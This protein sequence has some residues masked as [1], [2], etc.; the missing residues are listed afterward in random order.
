MTTRPAGTAASGVGG[1]GTGALSPVTSSL[2][3]FMFGM[4]GRVVKVSKSGS[5]A[6]AIISCMFLSRKWADNIGKYNR[7]AY[8]PAQIC[9]THRMAR[10]PFTSLSLTVHTG[11]SGT[12][13]FASGWPEALAE[14]QTPDEPSSI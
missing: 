13:T 4:D 3:V 14:M 1:P 7:L 10:L 6:C 2:C 5:L 11:A 8:L 12:G 9:K